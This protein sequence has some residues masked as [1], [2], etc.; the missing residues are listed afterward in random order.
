M[1]L[2]TPVPAAARCKVWVYCRSLTGI[3]VSN[4]VGGMDFSLC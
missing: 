3:V 1:Y 4:P 2:C